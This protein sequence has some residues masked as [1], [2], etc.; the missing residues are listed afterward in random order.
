MV[1]RRHY[2]YDANGN[3]S[4]LSDSRKGHK[5]FAYDPLDRLTEVRGQLNEHFV[6]DPAGNLLDQSIDGQ[7]HSR[8][9]NI[10]GNRLLMQIGRASCR[11]RV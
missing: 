9:A 10:K 5:S 6:H 8:Y 2:R 4:L 11:E 1:S 3:L 7:R